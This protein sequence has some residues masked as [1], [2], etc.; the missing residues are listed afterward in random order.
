[1]EPLRVAVRRRDTVEAVHRV[2]A[3]AVHGGRI[4]AQA[5]DP[6]LV[7]LFRSSAK[8][9]QALLLARARADVESTELAVACASHHAE[10]DQLE[11]VRR[12][13]GRALASEDDL[14]CGFQDGRPAGRV[15]HN[16][17]GKHAGFLAVC[18]ARGWQTAGYRLADHPLQ[19]E[20]VSEVAAAADLAEREMATAVDGCGV[21]TFGLSLERM[22]LAFSRLASLA[23]GTDVLAAMRAHPELIG[24]AQSVDTRLMRALPG[25][26]A[27]GGAEG[28]LCAVSPEGTGLALKCEDGSQR[29]LPPALASFCSLLGHDLL[30]LASVPVLN[31]RGEEVG[32]VVSE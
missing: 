32:E 4:V 13:L 19:R 17:S 26:V 31:S 15:Y 5:G 20:L 30:A 25:W 1:V 22:A 11:A 14:E 8:P 6:G 7:A 23:G 3:V 10:P 28:L 24:W 16:C 9:I 2:H 29:G 18:R 27:K 12:L 21:V